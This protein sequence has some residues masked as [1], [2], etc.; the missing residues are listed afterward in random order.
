MLWRVDDTEMYL[1]ATIHVLDA[2][3]LDLSP[4]SEAVFVG[5][6]RVAFEYALD[7]QPQVR[8]LIL[9]PA[10]QRLSEHVPPPLFATAGRKWIDAGLQHEALESMTPWFAAMCLSIA[11]AARRGISIEQGVD[12]QLWARARSEGRE[13]VGLEQPDTALRAFSAAPAAE[14][15]SMLSYAVDEAS[16]VELDLMIGAWRDRALEPFGDISEHRF[17]RL[18]QLF[19][20]LID[21]RNRAWLPDL[22]A[23]ARDGVPTVAAVGVL[24]CVGATGL[25]LLLSQTGIAVSRVE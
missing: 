23:M 6:R 19:S 7:V 4:E 11:V 22:T 3:P 18:P 21:D 16:Q 15:I 10:G 17:R 5:S 24:H 2:M 1:L 12:K 13:L 20:A 14:H 8:S 9:L 25:P